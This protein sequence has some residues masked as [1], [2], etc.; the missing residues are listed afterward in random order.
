MPMR[1]TLPQQRRLACRRRDLATSAGRAVK[2]KHGSPVRDAELGV[3]ET[4]TIWEKHAAF[5]ASRTRSAHVRTFALLSPAHKPDRA[6]I[7]APLLLVERAAPFDDPI[8]SLT[9]AARNW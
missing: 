6:D 5:E 7:D 4:A 8:G 9:V 2:P 3:S 1:R